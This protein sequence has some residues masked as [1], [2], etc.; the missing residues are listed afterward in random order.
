MTVDLLSLRTGPRAE[1]FPY[2]YFGQMLWLLAAHLP[3]PNSRHS[4]T[5]SFP[6]LI[7]GSLP[8]PLST[9]YPPPA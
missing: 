7:H 2:R 8:F 3:D 6:M 1:G 4:F 9:A 5:H